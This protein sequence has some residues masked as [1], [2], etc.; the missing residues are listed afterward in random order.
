MPQ[1]VSFSD[2]PEFSSH[3]TGSGGRQGGQKCLLVYLD[4]TGMESVRISMAT[5]V[6]VSK[7]GKE[8]L[9]GELEQGGTWFP[10]EANA[11]PR[12]EKNWVVHRSSWAPLEA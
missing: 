11:S 1:N 6:I 3:E 8:C 4:A 12:R 7:S 5:L 9:Q 10:S 2:V